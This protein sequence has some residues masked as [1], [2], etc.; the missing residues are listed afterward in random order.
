MITGST[1]LN[2]AHC[3]AGALD[4]GLS[5][6]GQARGMEGTQRPLFHMAGSVPAHD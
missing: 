6:G 1:T 2:H 3:P 5:S 4:K